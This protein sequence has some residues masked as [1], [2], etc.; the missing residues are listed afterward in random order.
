MDDGLQGVQRHGMPEM[1]AQT[2]RLAFPVG[3]AVDMLN[4]DRGSIDTSE[5]SQRAAGTVRVHLARDVG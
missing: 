1:P 4:H 3:R 5:R 2:R